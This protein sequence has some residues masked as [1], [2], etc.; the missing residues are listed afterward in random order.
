MSSIKPAFESSHPHQNNQNLHDHNTPVDRA[1]ASFLEQYLGAKNLSRLKATA[2]AKGLPLG[3]VILAERLL[4]R[5]GLKLAHDFLDRET[6]NSA[7]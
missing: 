6:N 4:S 3:T 2:T 5:D 1:L 7:D